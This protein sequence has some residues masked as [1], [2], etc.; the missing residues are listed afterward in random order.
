MARRL[1][2]E[3]A[4]SVYYAGLSEVEALKLVT[5]NPAKMLHIDNRVGSLKEGKDADVVIWSANPLLNSA[6][7][8]KTF[9]DG[10]LLFDEKTN[11]ELMLK[12][13]AERIRLFEKMADEGKAGKPTQK[14]KEEIEINK[15]CLD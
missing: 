1:N 5:L 11:E 12:N 14:A 3:A 7:V 9:V 13:K 15:H 2:Q 6:R 10:D 8:L 4:K